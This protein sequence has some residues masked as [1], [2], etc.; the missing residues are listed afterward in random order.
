MHTYT[1]TD[2][3]GEA[4]LFPLHMHTPTYKNIYTGAV[5]IQEHCPHT[6]WSLSV[7][8]CVFVFVLVCVHVYVCVYVLCLCLRL[9]VCL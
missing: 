3:D 8:V 7:F 2:I 1:H 6:S 4:E 5:K 9:H